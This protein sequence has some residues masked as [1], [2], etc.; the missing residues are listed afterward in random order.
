MPDP[1][2]IP[3]IQIEALTKSFGAL[4]VL[5]LALAPWFAVITVLYFYL[6]QPIPLEQ[7][8]FYTLFLL[9]GGMVL[10]A[11]AVLVSTMIEGEYTAPAV[12]FALLFAN[13]AI[14]ELAFWLEPF[15]I[16]RFMRARG[17]VDSSTWLIHHPFPWLGM[18]LCLLASASMFVVS[19]RI[20]KRRDF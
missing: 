8:W 12:A 2:Q 5:C 17:Y 19:T 3:A 11:M 16:M 1:A 15:S 9:G 4:E 13:L 14:C 6:R 10:F 7:I 20:L 18:T